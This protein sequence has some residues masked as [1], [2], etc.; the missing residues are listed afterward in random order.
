MPSENRD[1]DKLIIKMGLTELIGYHSIKQ[2]FNLNIRSNQ[3]AKLFRLQMV[4]I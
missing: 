4:L 2:K 3:I 1:S